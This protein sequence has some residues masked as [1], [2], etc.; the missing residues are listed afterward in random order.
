MTYIPSL[1][2]RTG[3]TFAAPE[4]RAARP[5]RATS[6]DAAR[7]SL[8]QEFRAWLQEARPNPADACE[9]AAS[10]ASAM[11][12]L[13]GLELELPVIHETVEQNSVAS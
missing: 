9:E 6:V 8:L 12:Q 10:T 3:Y 7:R 11:L 13:V 1:H 4:A 5:D 2:R